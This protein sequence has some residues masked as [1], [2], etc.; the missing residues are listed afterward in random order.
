MNISIMFIL[1]LI[2]VF[3]VKVFDN[4][5][6]TG[7][8]ILIQKNKGLLAGISVIISQIIFYKLIDAVSENGNLTMYVISIASGIGTMLAVKISDKFSKDRLFV[9]VLL[10]DDKN[11]MI[12]LREFLKKHHITNLATDGYTK[13]LSKKTIAITAY[14]ETKAENRLIDD[15]LST[16]N[17]KV[18]RIISKG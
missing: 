5:L 7:K 12:D 11:T 1:N 14:T 3:V 9:N 2:T 15:Y 17:V 10:C 4:V 13:N 6:S 18:K 8:T 16:L